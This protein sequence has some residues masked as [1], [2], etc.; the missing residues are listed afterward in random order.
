MRPVQSQQRLIFTVTKRHED[1]KEAGSDTS[2][3]SHEAESVGVIL[4]NTLVLYLLARQR[5]NPL[6]QVGDLH[7]A[8]RTNRGYVR[9][10]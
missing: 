3:S 9:I 7:C 1:L 4:F 6:K 10:V 8:V 5:K 2:S